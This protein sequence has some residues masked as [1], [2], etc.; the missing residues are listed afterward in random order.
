MK[1]KWITILFAGICLLAHSQIRINT[2]IY[3][4]NT[5]LESRSISFENPIGEPGEGGKLVNKQIGVGRKGSAYKVMPHH[6]TTNRL[7]LLR[8]R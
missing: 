3:K 5:P 8:E 2:D 7:L 1:K 6:H 4:V